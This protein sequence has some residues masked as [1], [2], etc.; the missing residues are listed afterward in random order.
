MDNAGE[1]YS[2]AGD[3]DPEAVRFFDVAH[4]GAQ[5][6][7]IAGAAEGLG[8]LRGMGPRSVAVVCTDQVSLAAVRAYVASRGPLELPVVIG[9]TVPSYVGPLDVVLFVGDT[10]A[11]EAD[12]RGLITAADRGAETVL[13]GPARGPL[14]DDA[15][16]STIIL[17]ALPTTAGPSP[18]RAAG[19]AGAVLAALHRDPAVIVDQLGLFA[20]EVDDELVTL[21]P[22]RE[23]AVNPARQLR[24]FASQARVL[25]SGAGRYGAAVAGLAAV[26]WSARGLPSGFVAADELGLAVEFAGGAGASQSE[27][28]FYDP[29][30]DPPS[31]LVPLKTVLWAQRET[32]APNTRAEWADAAHGE[33]AEALRL[34]TRAFA[35]TALSAS[36]DADERA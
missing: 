27:S 7:A 15:P 9:E 11:R 32:A 26:L 21:S 2:G 33:T 18:A 4:E 6:R 28:I 22:E 12:L 23:E 29:F 34:A 5:L 3:Y 8:R 36:G 13:A 14:V 10:A 25:H 1:Y 16:S 35:A 20:E 31:G 17:P 24:E 19:A 30:L